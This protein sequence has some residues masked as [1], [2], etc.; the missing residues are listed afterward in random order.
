MI[1]EPTKKIALVVA[2]SGDYTGACKM[3]HLYGCSLRNAGWNVSFVTGDRPDDGSRCIADVLRK[4]GFD[5]IEETGFFRL[6]DSS[7]ISRMKRHIDRIDPEF[8]V[9]VVQVDLKI[10]AP[11]SRACGKPYLVS[12]QTMHRFNGPL[13]LRW[14]KGVAFAREMRGATGIIASGGAVRQQAINEFKCQPERIAVVPNGIDTFAFLEKV[15]PAEGIPPRKAGSIRLLNV[16][17]LDPQKG[18]DILVKAVAKCI[19]HG[20]CCDLLLVGD[21]TNNHIESIRHAEKLRRLVSDLGIAEFVHFLGWRQDISALHQAADVYV[22]SA[23]WEGP[24]LPLVLVEAM[25]SALPVVL[26]D[27]VGWP[28]GFEQRVHGMVVKAG[29]VDDLS[30]GIQWIAALPAS[31]RGAIGVKARELAQSRYD[32]SVTGKQFVAFCERFLSS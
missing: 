7:L 31:E 20:I 14:L 18:Q 6:R 1:S 30:Q 29:D 15:A 9:S 5:V 26:T 17:R 23:L 10:V 2:G 13:L 4:D 22:H 32:V 27:C 11:A 24:P 16:G 19:G 3:A 25:A 12:D 28:E 8:V 21:A